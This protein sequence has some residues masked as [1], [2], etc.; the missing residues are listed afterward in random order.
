MPDSVVTPAPS[1]QPGTDLGSQAGTE[2]LT[3]S[4]LLTP[5]PSRAPSPSPATAISP[6]DSPSP[7][8]APRPP[9]D[10]A[11][12][13]R[14]CRAIL[15]ARGVVAARQ[16]LLTY[17]CDGLTLHRW[18]PP[19]VVLPETT[20]QVAALL[21][22]CHR[23]GVPFVARGSG[24][25]LS[26]GAVAE[27][28]SLVIATTRMRKVLAVDL[29]NRRITVQPGVIN[30]WVTRAVAG[31]GYYY[32]PDPSSQVV[33]S[34]GGNVAENSGG[35]HCLKYGVTSNHVL[36]MEVVL[37]DGTI[38][39]LGS[40]LAETPELDLR[41]V[42]I[43]SEG[44][45]GIATAITLRLL[46]APAS[47]AVLLADFT[48]MEAAAEA[49][50]GITA[51]G[52]LPA[53]M[54]MMDRL[55]IEAVN[56]YLG[57]QE[58]PHDAAAVLL[59]ELDGH[60]EEVAVALELATER[61]RQA[62]ARTVRLAREADDRARLWQG[63]KSAISALGRRFPSYYLQDGVVPRTALPEVMRA[64]G[65][66]SERYDLPVANVFHAGDGN[67]H[68]LILYRAGDPGVEQRVQELGAEILRL[69]I[70]AGGSISGEHGVGND[71]RCYMD[72]MFSPDDLATMQLVRQAFDP[73]GLANPGKL[74][75]TPKT[76]GESAQ[77]RREEPALAAVEV[78]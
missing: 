8:P 6:I 7:A 40:G 38:T 67:L 57:A 17:D 3:L 60:Q 31:D 65:E 36:E 45:L 59:V 68:P 34:I 70:A 63:R 1:I 69:C 50:R 15:P 33:C 13:E 44:T 29:P 41:G 32:A 64:I 37:P 75:P 62:G 11:A 28:P 23:E 14:R 26:G 66:L 5:G 72:W 49:V 54:E 10:W 78:F 74:F 25:G 39:T 27:T 42:F 53:G 21:R 61:C 71:K 56:D 77:R 12:I 46:R 58:Y 48:S 76:C 20:E 24:T 73:E 4:S 55:C 22:L 16:E 2:A 18:E 19:L 52:I 51:A 47:V 43:G 9:I 35:V 30:S